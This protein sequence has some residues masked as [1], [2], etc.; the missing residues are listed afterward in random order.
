MYICIVVLYYSF[1]DVL[2]PL[3]S[4]SSVA[5]CSLPYRLTRW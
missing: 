5:R 3:L 4:L 2:P 1:F